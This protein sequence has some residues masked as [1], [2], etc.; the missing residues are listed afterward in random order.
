MPEPTPFHVGLSVR[1]REAF[2]SGHVRTPRYIQGR[3]GVIIT[4]LGRWPNPEICA[5]G[6]DDPTGVNLYSV[7]FEQ[8][9]LWPDYSGSG[10]DLLVLDLYEHWLEPSAHPT[11]AE[12]DTDGINRE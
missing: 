10:K 3:T 7:E 8:G 6:L 2:I 9:M 1:V 11:S 5:K 12:S 4:S